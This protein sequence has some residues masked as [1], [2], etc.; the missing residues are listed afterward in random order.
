MPYFRL[1][2]FFFSRH[3]GEFMQ[4]AFDFFLRFSSLFTFK[5]H[6]FRKGISQGL[7][8]QRESEKNSLVPG[9]LRLHLGFSSNCILGIQQ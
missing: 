8:A 3:V 5:E 9:S 2:F 6:F 1:T 7:E 4:I